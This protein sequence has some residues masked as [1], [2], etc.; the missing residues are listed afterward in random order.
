M[1]FI[2][3]IVLLVQ[4]LLLGQEQVYQ[5]VIVQLQDIMILLIMSSVNLVLINAHHVLAIQHVVYAHHLLEF[6][7]QIVIVLLLGIW[8]KQV[9]LNANLAL[10]NVQLVLVRQQIV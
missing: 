7:L 3:Q 1:R 9:L 4:Y 8:I 2:L 6:Q 5:T 10:T